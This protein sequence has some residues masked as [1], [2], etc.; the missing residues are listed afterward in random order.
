MTLPRID[1]LLDHTTLVLFLEIDSILLPC[2]V[3]QLL[4][5]E[6][7]SAELTQVL[8]FEL[9]PSRHRH[10]ADILTSVDEDL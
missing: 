7:F 1:D 4:L 6:I 3:G 10:A 2:L 8:L 9:L 5:L